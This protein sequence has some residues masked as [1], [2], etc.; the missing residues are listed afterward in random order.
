MVLDVGPSPTYPSE[1]LVPKH[2]LSD[3]Q[4]A[5]R[6]GR[7]QLGR[8]RCLE[9]L[10]EDAALFDSPMECRDF[11][12][13]VVLALTPGDYGGPKL[14]RNPRTGKQNDNFDEYGIALPDNL[15]VTYSLTR[16]KTWYVKLRLGDDGVLVLSLHDLE[17]NMTTR[18]NGPLRPAWHPR[19]EGSR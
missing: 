19:K 10:Q 3:V 14:L 2:Q 4:A 17:F 15:M 13:D 16:E 7:F 1:E 11:A 9:F 6:A 12:R 5:V 18:P 8:S